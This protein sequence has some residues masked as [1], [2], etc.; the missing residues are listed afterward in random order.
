MNIGLVDVDGH[1]FPNF[2][3]MRISAYHK[4]QG[5]NVEWAM[6]LF[7]NYDRVYQSKIFTFTPDKTDFDGR[8]EVIRGGTGYDVRSQLDPL[9]ECITEMDY[10]LYP[11]Y[12]FSIQFLSRGCIRQCPFCLVHDKEGRI[13]SVLPAQLNPNG[14]W[15]EVLDNN[16]FANPDWLASVQY[17][18]EVGQ[19]VNLHG[20]DIRIMNEEQ[21]YWL[22]KLR[23]RRNIHIAWDLPAL[24]LTDKLREV[25]RYIKPYKI[26]CYVLVGFNSTIEQDMYRIE[27]LRSFGIKPYVM[28]YRD[29]ENK[30]T[31]SQYEKD[32][33]QYVNKLQIFKTCSFA[34]FMPRKGFKCS[35]YLQKAL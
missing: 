35:A 32:L 6:P 27:T 13:H 33:A 12:P 7:G 14:K 10:S 23:L 25:T 16:F 17:L 8:C 19:P 20:V 5:D 4:A 3:L 1:N 18:L 9:M 15:I 21:A 31:P 28:P 22:N 30:R 11:Q 29:F 2:A 24:D 34:D 26:M